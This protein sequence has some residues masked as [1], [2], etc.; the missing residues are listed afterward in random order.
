MSSDRV[1]E[2]GR[3]DGAD[4]LLKLND[5]REV[6]AAFLS[7]CREV[8]M[9]DLK[10]DFGFDVGTRLVFEGE[11]MRLSSGSSSSDALSTSGWSDPHSSVAGKDRGL[12]FFK[13]GQDLRLRNDPG[14]DRL[15]LDKIDLSSASSDGTDSADV[16][17]VCI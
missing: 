2:F 13:L 5:E 16:V 8:V 14:V 15:P 9:L 12:S 10:E 3:C 6:I 11:S 1:G 17:L 7:A 4:A